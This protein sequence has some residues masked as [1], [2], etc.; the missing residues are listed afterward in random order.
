MRCGHNGETAGRRCD[1]CRTA[2]R[3][4]YQVRVAWRRRLLAE[5]PELR[6]HGIASTYYTWGCRCKAC[7]DAATRDRYR[8][9]L[10]RNRL[11]PLSEWGRTVS[12]TQ[13]FGREWLADA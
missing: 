6:E 4:S 1:I 5:N 7:T 10:R 11:S 2:A 13:P 12:T 3:E 8:F 9:P